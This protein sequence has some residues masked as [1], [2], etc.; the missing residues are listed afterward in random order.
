[1]VA[2]LA[3]RDGHEQP[4]SRADDAAEL[5][6]RVDA[7]ARVVLGR[8]PV[9]RVV[10]ADV[11]ERRDEE[12]LVEGAVLER[13][14][15]DVGRDALHPGHVP[16]SEVG[17]REVDAGAQE[18]GQVGRLGE[19]VADLEDAALRHEPRE[20]P[21]H[22]DH[23]LVRAGR[24]LQPREPLAAR[25]GAEAE[26]DGVVERADARRLLGGHELVEERRA[27]ERPLRELRDGALARLGLGR[28]SQHLA[29]C[30]DDERVVGLA[31][32]VELGVDE[33]VH[34]AQAYS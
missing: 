20:H 10:G 24:G 22:L 8:E 30:A 29:E 9:R 13:Q 31:L 26:R 19:G 27:R 14:R 33:R 11:L 23:P 28:P 21:R 3:E 4:S 25:A 32:R 7:R 15:P 17:P 12:R 16:L 5:A 1:M 18:P 6:E 34:R 2:R